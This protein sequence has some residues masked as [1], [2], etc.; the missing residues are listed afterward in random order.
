MMGN[1]FS[2]AVPAVAL[3]RAE[4]RFR[5]ALLA[6]VSAAPFT[7]VWSTRHST[8]YEGSLF[9]AWLLFVVLWVVASLSVFTMLVALVGG[10]R[11]TARRWAFARA[12]IRPVE[13]LDVWQLRHTD[14]EP[15]FGRPADE[16]AAIS[17]SLGLEWHELLKLR[18]TLARRIASA[19][20][21][22]RARLLASRHHDADVT[23]GF[24][25]PVLGLS[26]SEFGEVERVARHLVFGFVRTPHARADGSSSS[27]ARHIATSRPGELKPGTLVALAELT[28]A[29]R[30]LID[31]MLS[32]ATRSREL[33]GELTVRIF[34]AALELD[35]LQ[36]EAACR[37]SVSWESDVL[38]MVEV[39]ASI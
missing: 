32:L 35:E 22:G 4:I 26:S 8:S 11:D 1:V 16:D 19:D 20:P 38:G 27:V 28:P 7:F 6:I 29:R 14:L 23:L 24:F 30:A 5:F 33:S 25:R 10:F 3:R 34:D 2:I 17:N 39:A 9:V 18:E 37:L 13:R 36:V 21:P 12:V 31:V 15:I